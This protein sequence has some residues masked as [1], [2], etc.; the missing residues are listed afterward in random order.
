VNFDPG[1]TGTKKLY[2]ALHNK[3]KEIIAV[4]K[5]L[6]KQWIA[7]TTCKPRSPTVVSCRTADALQN[8]HDGG[9]T[10]P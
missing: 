9:L 10:G 5:A 3:V 2:T 4:R 1:L 8:G 6:K 7:L